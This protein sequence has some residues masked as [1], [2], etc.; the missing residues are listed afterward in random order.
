MK[1]TIQLFCIV[2]LA[3]IIGFSFAA[4]AEPSNDTPVIIPGGNEPTGN[5]TWGTF[6][7]ASDGGSSTINM[8]STTQGGMSARR[9]TGTVTSQYE[10]GYTGWSATPNTATL[11]SLKTAAGFSFNVIGD[12]KTYTVQVITSDVTDYRYYQTT[13]S[14]SGSQ[15]TITIKMNSLSQPDWGT[16]FT[17]V[18]FNQNNI[19]HIQFQTPDSITR[20]FNYDVTIWNIQLQS[21]VTPP[22]DGDLGNYDYGWHDSNNR[23]YQHAVWVLN[24]D[25]LALAKTAGTRLELALSAA[26][27]ASMQLVW[28]APAAE[29]W[30]QDDC[31][32]LGWDGNVISGKGITWNASTR[33]LTINLSLALD[34]YNN[35]TGRTESS[36]NLVIAYYGSNNIDTLGITS[37]TLVA[38]GGEPPPP[39]PL[40]APITIGNWTWRTFSDSVSAITMMR[41][42][43]QN[44]RL[45]FNGNI[46]SHSNYTFAGWSVS[47]N[48]AALAHLKTTESFSFKVIGDGRT[49]SVQVLTFDVT[50]HRYHQTTFNT[51]AGTEQT[52]TIAMNSLSQPDWGT[53]APDVPFNQNNV[54]GI[55][56]QT[57]DD[58]RPYDFNLTMWDLQLSGTPPVP[59]TI[60]VAV[61]P[62]NVIVNKGAT[63]NF[64][65]TVTGTDTQTVTWSI[66]QG[67]K[68][69]GTTI[70]SSGL[71]TV[72]AG[73][74]LTTLTIR[75]ASTVNPSVSGTANVTILGGGNINLDEHSDSMSRR[76]WP[77]WGENMAVAQAP[78]TQLVLQ[79]RND[80]PL[81]RGNI[82]LYWYNF[83]TWN[84][85]ERNQ[86]VSANNGGITSTAT[87]VTWNDSAKTITIT[88]SEALPGYENFLYEQSADLY[89]IFHSLVS[90]IGLESAK[91]VTNTVTVSDVTVSPLSMSIPKGGH[92]NFRA[93]VTGTGNP[94]P[95]RTVTW[96]VTGTTNPGTTI[97]RNGRLLVAAN[98]SS[99][100]ITVRATSTA[101][102][103]KYGTATVTVLQNRGQGRVVPVTFTGS[104]GSPQTVN[105]TGLSGNDVYLIKFN[106]RN[107]SFSGISGNDTGHITEP[108][109][110]RLQSI[111]ANSLQ[112][113]LQRPNNT[114]RQ[115]RTSGHPFITEF[116]ANPP[117]IPAGTQQLRPNFSFT[118]PVVGNTRNFFVEDDAHMNSYTREITATL[119]ATGTY[120]NIWVADNVLSTAAAQKVAAKFDIM[121]P[122]TTNIFGYEFGGGPGGEGGRDGDP[123]VQILFYNILD[124]RVGGY[125]FS[126]DYYTQQYLD[127]RGMRSTKTNNA[128][129]FYMNADGEET[130]EELSW[131]YSTMVH[132]LQHMTNFN[133]RTVKRGVNTSAWFNEMLS[134]M[135]EDLLATHIDVD[136][137]SFGHPISRIPYFLFDYYS[138]RLRDWRNDWMSYCRHYAFGAYLL[139][140]YGGAEVAKKIMTAGS[141]NEIEAILQALNIS[142]SGSTEREE[143]MTQLQKKFSEAMIFSGDNIP[144]GAHTF[145]KTV[146]STV[147]GGNGT[148]YTNHA[149]NIW[150]DFLDFFALD[151]QEQWQA[152][153][154]YI[155]PLNTD[156]RINL[157]NFTIHSHDGWKN[158]SGDLT[159]NFTRP[160]D[161][162]VDFI[163]MVR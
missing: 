82:Q 57:P 113:P 153:G 146:T 81:I 96:S 19:T 150:T 22:A 51:I 127:D 136:T 128:E 160:S 33:K 8:T 80:A 4:C 78:G 58:L 152:I 88:L 135:A 109:L 137:K 104:A 65:A 66:D 89:I 105:L 56:F 38:D 29:I 18:P 40:D 91:L 50:D 123:K 10:Y 155:H 47:P 70:N 17:D 39:P 102:A 86:I 52:I 90:V 125:F 73:E 134:M 139:R 114:S 5:W 69:P 141:T 46:I 44:N 71:L 151:K 124:P 118:P 12:G 121:Y 67:N 97:N 62:S 28:Q 53:G 117:P 68:N 115:N 147:T 148:S 126:K 119:L 93:T 75:A 143:K 112:R 132:E 138:D 36:L 149:F 6:N 87:G 7:D 32:I 27:N 76:T 145:D 107:F 55:Q 77:L 98:E 130:D 26:P 92:H 14:T 11:A 20:P 100:S 15:Q 30:W 103:T 37:A 95:P 163:I 161:S 61:S 108:T 157:G 72:A 101:D 49:Y 94:P 43:P 42:G 74:T 116:N 120:G 31:N 133:E 34:D 3:F 129:I 63:Q 85:S 24:S 59:P 13:F 9:F 156:T 25:N 162:G 140:N 2:L 84:D 21:N 144:A 106:S 154:P 45:T 16:G 110:S 64:N 79:F 159:I 122:A 1:N 23:N 48:A 111:V 158:V 142:F 83:S 54:M 35:F 60:S 131:I 99:T 41:S